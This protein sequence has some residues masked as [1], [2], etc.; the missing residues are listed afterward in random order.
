M[1]LSPAL[2]RILL[3]WG[4]SLNKGEKRT[5]LGA[6]LGL[7]TRGQAVLQLAVSFVECLFDP[8]KHWEVD[9]ADSNPLITDTETEA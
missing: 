3:S 6:H 1:A 2:P 7:G 9:R 4:S 5:P 8:Q